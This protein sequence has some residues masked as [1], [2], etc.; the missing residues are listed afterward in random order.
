MKANGERLAA[1]LYRLATMG[2]PEL[3]FPLFVGENGER[4]LSDS[5]VCAR[6]AN[7]LSA[8]IDDV[9]G[10]WVERD[11]R[12][13]LLTLMVSQ[14]G[15]GGFPASSLS[16]GTLRFLALALIEQDP[17]Y[18][19]V[20][21]LEEPENGL[22]PSRIPPML[23]LLYNIAVGLEEEISEENVNRQVIFNTHNP[24]VVQNVKFQDL[25]MAE[26]RGYGL[27]VTALEGT[28]RNLPNTRSI[29]PGLLNSYL[30]PV[31]RSGPG[32]DERELVSGH[33]QLEL[34]FQ[35]EP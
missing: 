12:R 13:Q 10:V 4:A 31:F 18:G 14:G 35:T 15:N 33:Q 9:K 27:K 30:Y 32:I 29:P 1:A 8:L 3:T 24:G 11:E 17:E 6:M 26:R 16:D 22:H 23:E 34:S 5:R 2:E 28:W 25:V 20:I 7:R 21:C 19:G